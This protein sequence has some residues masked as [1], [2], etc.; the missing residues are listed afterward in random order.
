MFKKKKE[1]EKLDLPGSHGQDML[2]KKRLSYGMILT[3]V[4]VMHKLSQDIPGL[5]TVS[6]TFTC[7]S[8]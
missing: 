3:W 4:L 5:T 6:C 8:Q 2:A 1:R 7:N